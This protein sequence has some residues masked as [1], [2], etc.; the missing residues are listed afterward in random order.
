MFI[1]SNFLTATGSV[2]DMVLWLY[3]LIIIVHVIASWLSADPYNPIVRFL[4]NATEP[5]LYKIRQYLPV[6]FGGIDF[7]PL[8]A[9]AGI[10]FL[11]IFLVRS[12]VDLA[13]SLR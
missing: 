10:K 1:L 11:Q 5:L 13:I 7:S 9:L 8:V 3:W 2:L 12:L 4:R 6:V